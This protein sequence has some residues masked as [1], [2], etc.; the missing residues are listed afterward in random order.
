MVIKLPEDMPVTFYRTFQ[1]VTQLV[2][3]TIAYLT[4]L[5]KHLQRDRPK[6]FAIVSFTLVFLLS[7]IWV[8][9]FRQRRYEFKNSSDDTILKTRKALEAL[10]VIL[11]PTKSRWPST[12]ISIA[13]TAAASNSSL[14]LPISELIQDLNNGK[15]EVRNPNMLHELFE[16]DPLRTYGWTIRLHTDTA[17]RMDVTA[18]LVRKRQRILSC[19]QVILGEFSTALN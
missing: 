16:A 5:A 3:N 15:L 2:E 10:L 12:Y 18:L 4:N 11:T 19:Y 7:L 8:Q 6:Q 13:E 14:A 9:Y 1:T 17:W